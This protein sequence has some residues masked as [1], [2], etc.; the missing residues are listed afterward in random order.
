MGLNE[1]EFDVEMDF[2]RKCILFG[3]E[4]DME[5]LYFL[6]RALSSD[7]NVL[8]S[9]YNTPI[10]KFDPEIVLAQEQIAK[11][12]AFYKKERKTFKERVGLI[13]NW[14][15]LE[16]L[17]ALVENAIAYGNRD[18][19]R[20]DNVMSF[21]DETIEAKKEEIQEKETSLKPEEFKEYK[22]QTAM[23]MIGLKEEAF[24]KLKEE[25]VRLMA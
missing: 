20:I 13:A 21:T 18:D 25:V 9:F 23:Q 16:N 3:E 15:G 12:R 1:I 22:K 7:A 17:A 8:K 11:I 6:Q 19:S 24:P 4:H 14:L 5:E 2:D 10:Q